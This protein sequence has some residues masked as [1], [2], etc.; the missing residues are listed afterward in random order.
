MMQGTQ[1]WGSMT[2]WRDEVRREVGGLVL[3]GGDKRKPMMDSC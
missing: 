2:T 1:S 3:E